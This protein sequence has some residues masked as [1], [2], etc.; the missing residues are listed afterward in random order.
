MDK[1]KL[2]ETTAPRPPLAS[3]NALKAVIVSVG[4]E[5][6]SD[7][8]RLQHGIRGTGIPVGRG[9]RTG[10]GISA[11]RGD[12]RKLLAASAEGLDLSRRDCPALLP[13]PSGVDDPRS[14]SP[15]PAAALRPGERAVPSLP[16]VD[17]PQG[18]HPPKPCP[19]PCGI[20]SRIFPR[21][22]R[23]HRVAE[24][25]CAETRRSPVGRQV[26]DIPA[27]ITRQVEKSPAPVYKFMK[28]GGNPG[29][30]PAA[31]RPPRHAV[32]A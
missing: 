29:P 11:G 28:R 9:H 4:R 6:P 21:A 17:S 3:T 32:A 16:A 12:H 13:R 23:E 30:P 5:C 24:R 25:P 20:T 27:L 2:H 10:R 15:G 31:A 7:T 22:S 26:L 1:D 8:V 18:H 19:L 14:A